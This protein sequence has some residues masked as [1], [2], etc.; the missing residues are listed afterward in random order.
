MHIGIADQ[1]AKRPQQAGGVK[2]LGGD[3]PDLS[4]RLGDHRPVAAAADKLGIERGEG[5][6]R[7]APA[8]AK[9]VKPLH[10]QRPLG[11]VSGFCAAAMGTGSGALRNGA[12]A[13]DIFVRSK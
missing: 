4:Q 12:R 8:C 6:Q 13:A 7:P 11:A 3:D 5:M 1:G 2:G 10:F 9:A